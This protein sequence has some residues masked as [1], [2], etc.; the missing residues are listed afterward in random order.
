M[1]LTALTLA[2]KASTQLKMAEENAA[3]RRQ[4][5]ALEDAVARLREQ[6]Q[7]MTERAEA[8]EKKRGRR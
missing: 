3:L 1:S 2:P 5:Y 4:I 6:L 7:A 8:A